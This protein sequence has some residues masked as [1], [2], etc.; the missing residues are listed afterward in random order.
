MQ[1]LIAAYNASV[2]KYKTFIAGIL[3]AAATV[4]TAAQSTLDPQINDKIRKEATENSQIMRTMHFLS[5]VYGPRLTGSPN[6]K[7]AAEWAAK[8]MTEWGFVNAHLEPWEWGHPGWANEHVEAH[9]ESPMKAALVVQPLAWSP[10]TKGRVTA[11]AIHLITPQGPEV[12]G[13]GG[14]GPQRQGPTQAELA[15]YLDTLKGKV[16]GAAVLVGRHVSVPP[17]F[18]AEATRLS[19]VDAKCRYSEDAAND[20]ECQ[21]RGGRGQ[22]G[23]RGGAPQPPSD[24]LTAQQVNRQ[25]DE[26]LVAN[27]AAL[28]IDDAGRWNG[29]V[30]APN[31]RSYDETKQVP[32]LIM[33]NDDFGRI[34][35]T[36]ADGTPVTLGFQITNKWYPEGHTSFN[37]IAEIPGTDK[38]DEVVMLGGHLDSWHVATGATDNAIGSAVMMEAARILKALGV[39][40]RRTIRVALWSGEEQGLLGSL[41]YVEQHFGTVEHPK[42]EFSKLSAYLNVDTGTGKVRG[43]SIFGPPEAAAILRQALAPFKDLGVAGA[44]AT[45]SRATG[46]TDSTSFNHAGLPGVGFGQDAI[47]YNPHTHHTNLDT[48]ERIIEEDVK[49]SATV[50]AGVLYQLAMRDEMIPRFATDTMPPLPAGRGGF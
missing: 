15:A 49:A 42:P 40:P 26:F 10:G 11:K 30:T 9:I 47:D 43:A 34:A 38:K 12:A 45:Q 21:G 3:V 37:T 32:T 8:Q 28:R 46:G 13:G 14:R 18:T 27:K 36:L 50:I 41:A 20:P 2:M 39:K 5:D 4:F 35:R 19:D 1:C 23:G 24:R 48:Y 33:R 6:H 22:R 16:T 25:I 7:A 29:I 17:V 44:S 31:A